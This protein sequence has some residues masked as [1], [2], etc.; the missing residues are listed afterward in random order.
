LPKPIDGYLRVHFLLNKNQL[1][2]TLTAS[3]CIRSEC[4]PNIDAYGTGSIHPPYQKVAE[5]D[6]CNC[7]YFKPLRL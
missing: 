2:R 5:A 6:K 1:G 3:T 4:T 7:N